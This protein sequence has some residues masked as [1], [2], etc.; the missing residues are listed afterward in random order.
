VPPL[1]IVRN[2]PPRRDL[3]RSRGMPAV[4]RE[5]PPRRVPPAS[6]VSAAAIF[7]ARPVRAPRRVRAARGFIEDLR[8][9]RRLRRGPRALHREP[10]TMTFK[11]GIRDGAISAAV[12]G[13][14]L[15]ALVSADPRVHDHVSD[16]VAGTGSVGPWGDRLSDL[17]SALW[18]A[19]KDQSIDNAPML[20][21]ATVGAVLT[22]FMLKS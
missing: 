17:G 5:A 22:L 13:V 18:M 12:F 4:P 8:A 19:L 15:F 14:V 6:F 11:L 2:A 16:L 3:R 10:R 7:V 9:A 20:V 21:F 1:P